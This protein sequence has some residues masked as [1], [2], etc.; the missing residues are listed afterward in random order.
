[1]NFSISKIL[2]FEIANFYARKSGEPFFVV[3]GKFTGYDVVSQSGSLKVEIKFEENA[4]HTMNLCVE[5]AYGGKPSG[6]TSTFADIWVHAVPVSRERIWCYEFDVP[7]LKREIEALPSYA[8]G[9]GKRSKVKLL[10]LQRAERIKRS[11]FML[12]VDWGQYVPYWE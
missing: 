5:V 9:D 2:E 8:A 4:S 10:P 7:E 12:T 1:M 11:K 3:A 6:I